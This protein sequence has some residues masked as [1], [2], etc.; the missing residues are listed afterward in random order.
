MEERSSGIEDTIK[1]MDTLV[2]ENVK[3]K[4]KTTSA[5]KHPGNLGYY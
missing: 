5:T 1:E 4:T 3:F 2:K